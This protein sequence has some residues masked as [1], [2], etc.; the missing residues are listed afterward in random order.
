LATASNG[1][2]HGILNEKLAEAAGLSAPRVYQT[3]DGRR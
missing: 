3:R 1:F 2:D